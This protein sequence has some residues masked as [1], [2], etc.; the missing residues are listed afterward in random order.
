MKKVYV[1]FTLDQDDGAKCEGVYS[2]PENIDSE[3]DV[4]EVY[5]VVECFLDGAIDERKFDWRTKRG[6][7]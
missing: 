7:N 5:T 6:D 3:V 1:L 4:G 2:L